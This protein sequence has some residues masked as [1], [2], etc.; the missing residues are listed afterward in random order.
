VKTLDQ[1]FQDNPPFYPDHFTDTQKM[2]FMFLLEDGRLVGDSEGRNHTT[3]MGWNS[4]DGDPHEI[5]RSLCEQNKALRICFQPFSEKD[6]G[7]RGDFWSLYVQ[8][9]NVFPNEAQWTTLSELYRL[10]GWRDTIVVSDVYAPET[11]RG[12]IHGQSSSLNDLK[13]L[14]DERINEKPQKTKPR[15][16]K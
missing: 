7:T 2:R 13:R 5:Q 14:L 11:K 3:L 6:D 1:I 4:E 12:W 8:I 9:D 16:S 10:K 15:R